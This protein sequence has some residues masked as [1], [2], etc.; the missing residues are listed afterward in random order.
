L[1]DTEPGGFVAGG[2]GL[3]V[4][5]GRDS[6]AGS[7]VDYFDL[8][9]RR[10]RYSIPLRKDGRQAASSPCGVSEAAGAFALHERFTSRPPAYVK[11]VATALRL[12]TLGQDTYKSTTHVFSVATGRRLASIPSG[13]MAGRVREGALSPD[14]QTLVVD[15]SNRDDRRIAIYDLPIRRSWPRILATALV[16]ALAVAN[17]QL[18]LATFARWV[19]RK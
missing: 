13:E 9:E 6:P 10:V 15:A 11:R 2:R 16:V 18:L 19:R 5:R 3:L 4:L 7:F 17:V 14:G 12:S 8:N 1:R